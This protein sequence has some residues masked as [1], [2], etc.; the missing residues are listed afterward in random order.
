MKSRQHLLVDINT[1]DEKLLSS[2]L[3]IS[4]RLSKRIIAFR[5]YKSI[6]QLNQ[7][8]GIDPLTLDRIKTLVKIESKNPNQPNDVFITADEPESRLSTLEP[9]AYEMIEESSSVTKPAKAVDKDNSNLN[10]LLFFIILIGAFFRF[11]G[12]NWDL[13]KHQHPDERYITDVA[14]KIQT[15][16]SV[17]E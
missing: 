2:S 16:S 11:S 5:P 7:V 8:W 6:D 14:T 4:L 9:A 13:N 10:L 1:A 12:I 3:K 17:K 15:V